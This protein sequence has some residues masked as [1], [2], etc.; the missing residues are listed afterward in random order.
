[1]LMAGEASGDLLAAE[2]VSAL[3]EKIPSSPRFLGAGGP[4]MAAV[5]VELAFDLTRH[6]VIGV[7][8][9]LKNYFKF[10][11]LFNQLLQLAIDQ[12][13]DAIIG[14][15]YGGFNLRFG[16]AIKQYV[17]K[18][19]DGWNPKIIQFVSPQ[20]WASRPGRADRLA[21][22]YD[23]LLSIFPFEKD[24]YVRRVP[25]LRVEFVGHPMIDRFILEGQVPRAPM[26]EKPG[27]PGDRPT[28]I[29]LLPG[30]RKSELQRHLPPMLRA[31]DLIQDQFPEVRAKM[32]LPN[33]EL[34]KELVISMNRISKELSRRGR[35]LGLN[36]MPSAPENSSRNIEFQIGNLPQALRQAEIAIASTGTVT[37]ECAFFGVP[38]VTLYKT[39]WLTYEIARRI[40]TVK[41]LTMPNLLAKEEIF[42]E[43]V[44]DAATPENIAGAA[45]A[46]LQNEPRR[47]KIKSQ[48]AKIIA[49]LGEP[50]AA[51]RAAG[52]IAQLFA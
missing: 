24:W 34:K 47:Q 15:D 41:S 16:H 13:P 20:V 32:V 14:V 49:T 6:S 52:A 8:D 11:R 30:S 9:V 3:R 28:E 42:P 37:M 36:S 23:L 46:L 12:K 51:K 33:L 7:S 4:K 35:K 21:A 43:F 10:R 39:S 27:S 5:G 48:L 25:Q 22:D 26:P 40:V 19:P 31:L 17:R 2:L 45:L 50:G 29:L 38:T 18:H 1:M 44:Q